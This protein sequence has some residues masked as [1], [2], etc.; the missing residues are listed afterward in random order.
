MRHSLWPGRRGP[1]RVRRGQVLR[2]VDRTAPGCDTA[3]AVRGVIAHEPPLFGLLA[4][5]PELAVVLGTS[6]VGSP[7]SSNASGPVTMRGQPGS[8]SRPWPSDRGCGRSS[9]TSFAKSS[10]VTRPPTSTSAAIRISWPSTSSPVRLCSLSESRA[11]PP[12]RR[13]CGLW[14]PHCRTQRCSR[15]PEPDT[16]PTS[17]I[18]T[19]GGSDEVVHPQARVVPDRWSRRAPNASFDGSCDLSGQGRLSPWRLRMESFTRSGRERGA[20]SCRTGGNR[21]PTA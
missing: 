15:W 7:L 4:G 14:P 5:D 18:P 2:G 19:V 6:E 9:P 12:S 13:S 10:C 1:L 8:S 20:G 3:S 17:P 21:T 11:H 16:S